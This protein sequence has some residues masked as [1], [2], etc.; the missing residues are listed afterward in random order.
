[1]LD[2]LEEAIRC[3]FV[4]EEGV[5]SQELALR[6]VARERRVPLTHT[7]TTPNTPRRAQE[8]RETESPVKTDDSGTA[9]SRKMS[10]TG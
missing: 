6:V 4:H 8:L 7:P 9:E 5:T 10:T 3:G 1:M 2:E